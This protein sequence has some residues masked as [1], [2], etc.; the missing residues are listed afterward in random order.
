MSASYAIG[1]LTLSVSRTDIDN[2]GYGRH[3]SGI[4]IK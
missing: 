3:K 4:L 1:S 2:A